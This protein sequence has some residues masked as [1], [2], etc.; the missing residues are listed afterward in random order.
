MNR[1]H[2]PGS[3]VGD[4]NWETIGGP[5]RQA[6]ARQIGYQRIAFAL[7]AGRFHAQNPV[8]VNLLGGG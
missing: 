8:G 2:R 1:S 4:Q 6:D 7:R 5:D 3:R